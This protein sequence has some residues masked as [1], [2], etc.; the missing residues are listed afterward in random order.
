MCE[1][2][3][4]FFS[5]CWF[6]GGRT[7]QWSANIRGMTL[8]VEI[9]KVIYS[10]VLSFCERYNVLMLSKMCGYIPK[11]SESQSKVQHENLT[12]TIQHCVD[13]L[14][15]DDLVWLNVTILFHA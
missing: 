13:L 8:N 10:I 6:V 14:L 3:L 12:E 7:P 5:F 4:F 9:N 2:T 15:K 1:I 11:D